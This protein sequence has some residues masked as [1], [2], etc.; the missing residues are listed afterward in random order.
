MAKFFSSE[1]IALELCEK[2]VISSF[3]VGGILDSM[4]KKLEEI[5]GNILYINLGG[6]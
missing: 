6:A 4:P 2:E 5:E 3:F 1:D